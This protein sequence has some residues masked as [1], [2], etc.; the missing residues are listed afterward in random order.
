MKPKKANRKKE[1]MTGVTAKTIAKVGIDT[2]RKL[3]LLIKKLAFRGVFLKHA[4]ADFKRAY[5]KKT[6]EMHAGNPRR[7]AVVLGIK[8][9]TLARR[10]KAI[11]S[12]C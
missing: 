7:A 6:L 3:E 11:N 1:T 10:M 5:L 12:H 2:D 4:I 9:H 8:R